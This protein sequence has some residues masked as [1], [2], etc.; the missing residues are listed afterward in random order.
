MHWLINKLN[1]K[2]LHLQMIFKLGNIFFYK[3]IKYH[4]INILYLI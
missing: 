2:L 3:N 1:K 4:I